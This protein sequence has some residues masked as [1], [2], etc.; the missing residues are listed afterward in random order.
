MMPP[1]CLRYSTGPRA[2]DAG[3]MI[4]CAAAAA[5]FN[6]ASSR[7]VPITALAA[8]VGQQRRLGEIGEADRA[9]RDLAAG[10][11]E[12]DGGGGGGVV[13]DLALEFFV[14]VAVA[15]RRHGN[16]DR[17]EDF[18]G[19]ERGEIGALVE[20]ARR[21]VARAG[22]AFEAVARAQRHH[23]RRHVVAGIAV[24][25]I[26]ADGAAVAHLRIGDQQR[27]LVQDRQRFRRSRRRPAT[28]AGWSWRRSRS[29]CRRGGCP[30]ARQC[31]A[32]STRCVGVGQPELHHR[33]QAVAAGQR[34]G[35]IAEAREQGSTASASVAGRW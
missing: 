17:G 5:F 26:A 7:L 16:R 35:L 27:R 4:A 34:P 21:D 3:D 6:E 9:G 32:R 18:A 13:A 31:R 24:G 12:H 22:L 25:D 2:S 23:Q 8:S 19:L 11:G 10:H 28:R 29:C 14:G 33:N 20:L 1:T 15:G 30:S